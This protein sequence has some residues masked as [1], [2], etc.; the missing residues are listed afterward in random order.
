M[1]K[2][3][4]IDLIDAC[5]LSC[6]L[7][8]R[9]RLQSKDGYIPLNDWI[10]IIDEYPN[11]KEIYFIGTRGE[12]TLY[13][14][15]L[16]LCKYLK[17]RGIS[18]LVSTNGCTNKVDWWGELR[19]ILDECDEVRFAIDGITQDI[20]E[21]YRVG[22]DLSRVMAN[23][24]EFKSDKNNDTIQYVRF[25]HNDH[26]DIS[27]FIKQFSELRTVNSSQGNEIIQQAPEDNK[28]YEVVLNVALTRKD[29]NIVCETK[30]NMHFINHKGV[31]SPCCHYNENIILKGGVWD[32]TYKDIENAKHDFC[33]IICDKFCKNLRD[34]LD[35]EL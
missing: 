18:I 30:N 19:D 3:L 23:F 25:A 15:F 11:I 14:E 34:S 1:I 9:N 10:K 8:N 28:K 32:K 13:P 26:E 22:G 17:G 4:E 33:T 7:C 5:N 2:H 35:I 12:P 21:I 16:E 24:K 20:Y 31:V 29:H 6:P 27:E